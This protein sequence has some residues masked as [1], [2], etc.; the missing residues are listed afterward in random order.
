[1][2]NRLWIFY[3]DSRVTIKKLLRLKLNNFEEFFL[4]IRSY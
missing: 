2:V 4:E 3:W 1:M